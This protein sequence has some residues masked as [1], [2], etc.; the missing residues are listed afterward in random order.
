MFIETQPRQIPK[1]EMKAKEIDVKSRSAAMQLVSS[2]TG[3]FRSV[4]EENQ[5]TVQELCDFMGSN[6]YKLFLFSRSTQEFLALVVANY[7]PLTMPSNRNAIVNQDGTVTI[8]V[9]KVVNGVIE[10]VNQSGMTVDDLKLIDKEVKEMEQ[11][12]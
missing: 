1:V 10:W 3:I 4:W 2:H 12:S 7:T 6:A 11:G 8:Q 9:K 5:V